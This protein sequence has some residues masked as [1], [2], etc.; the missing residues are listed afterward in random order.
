[1]ARDLIELQNQL[2]QPP[3]L[4]FATTAATLERDN[5]TNW[6]IGK[7]P[8]NPVRP[9]Q[10]AAHRL[11]R[12]A[13]AK[14]RQHCPAPVRHPRSRR[15]RHRQGSIALMALQL[16]KSRLKDLNKG[17]PDFTPTAMLLKHLGV[18]DLREAHH[19]RRARPRP[20]G[21]RHPAA[22]R[23]PLEE[24]IKRARSRLPAVKEALNR[25]LLATAQ[26]YS[27]L[28]NSK[29]GRHPLAHTLRE[30]LRTP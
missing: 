24:Q 21:R 6:D 25:Y 17:L 4:P 19:R 20:H 13:T 2:G 16:T 15:S 14:K 11:P 28:D 9:R 23:K 12:P 26:A 5:L 3:P 22:R 30:Q 8:K 7:L 29:I 10:T 18:D 27:E 1:M